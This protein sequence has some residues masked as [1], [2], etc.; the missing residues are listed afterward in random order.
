MGIFLWIVFGFVAGSVAM[1]VMPGKDHGGIIITILL[2]IFG[3]VVGGFIGTALGF[4]TVT[5]FDSRSLMIA[6]TGALMLLIGYRLVVP[7]ATA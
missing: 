4:G 3:A 5:G 1:F 7:R 6:I 2:G